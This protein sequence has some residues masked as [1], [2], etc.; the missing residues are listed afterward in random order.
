MHFS[1]FGTMHFAFWAILFGHGN[2]WNN[3]EKYI[4]KKLESKN[5]LSYPKNIEHGNCSDMKIYSIYGKFTRFTM[6]N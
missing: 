1:H 5:P 6:K 2:V 3:I 4:S